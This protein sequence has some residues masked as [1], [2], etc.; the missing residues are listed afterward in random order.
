MRTTWQADHDH[1]VFVHKYKTFEQALLN[2]YTQKAG[3]CR[4]IGEKHDNESTNRQYRFCVK[5]LPRLWRLGSSN[6]P[7]YYP[8]G[9]S[10]S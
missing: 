1:P 2:L 10:L 6:Q 3:R 4:V 8:V 9:I 7:I 5:I